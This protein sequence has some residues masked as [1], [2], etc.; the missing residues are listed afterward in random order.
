VQRLLLEHYP[1]FAEAEIE[2]HVKTALERWPLEDVLVIH[3]VGELRPGDTIVFV[4]AASRHRRAAFETVDFLMDYLK[5]EAPFWKR[6]TT[7]DGAAWIEPRT[8]D[9]RDRARWHAE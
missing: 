3:R 9:H 1:G 7:P 5:S 8:E 6:E 2:L 4:A